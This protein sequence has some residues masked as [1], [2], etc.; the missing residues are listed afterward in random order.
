MTCK[1]KNRKRKARN[2]LPASA[3]NAFLILPKQWIHAMS[4]D[5]ELTGL[6]SDSLSCNSLPTK[7]VG[8]PLAFNLV[9]KSGETNQLKRMYTAFYVN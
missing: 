7:N 6:T 3:F 5:D 2:P 8:V 4:S 1:R 9:A